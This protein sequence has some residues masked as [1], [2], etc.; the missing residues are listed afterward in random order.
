MSGRIALAVLNGQLDQS[1]YALLIEAC[2]RIRLEDLL[3]EV[4]LEDAAHIVTGE[5]VGHLGQVV[6]TEGEE[7]SLFCDLVRR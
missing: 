4:G 1:A 2:K 5:A 7:L 6:G 3:L